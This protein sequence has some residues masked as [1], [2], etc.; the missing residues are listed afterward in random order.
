MLRRTGRTSSPSARVRLAKPCRL[1]FVF[2]AEPAVRDPG[3]RVALAAFQM[4]DA[5]VTG[6]L[7]A[8][9]VASLDRAAGRLGGVFGKQFLADRE[10]VAAGT[11]RAQ[12]VR[13]AD[14]EALQ[15]LGRDEASLP[16]PLAA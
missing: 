16:E 2:R 15:P 1:G 9:V 6:R 11:A 13:R 8:E 4:I 7:G 12:E 3:A 10:V 5:A 14:G